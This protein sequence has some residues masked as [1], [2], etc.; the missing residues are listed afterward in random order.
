MIDQDSSYVWGV[1]QKRLMAKKDK[2]AKICF[3]ERLTPSSF[4][5]TCE[6]EAGGFVATIVSNPEKKTICPICNRKIKWGGDLMDKKDY[7][8]LHDIAFMGGADWDKNEIIEL[9]PNEAEEHLQ[10]GR[11][12]AIEDVRSGIRRITHVNPKDI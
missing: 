2:K 5:S 1:T 6:K 11:I 4:T 12:V 9:T 10:K 8:V 7:V 3:W